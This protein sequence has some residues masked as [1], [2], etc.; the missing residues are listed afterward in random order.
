MEFVAGDSEIADS[1][2]QRWLEEDDEILWE[3]L[4][5]NA[6]EKSRARLFRG[7]HRQLSMTGARSARGCQHQRELP[8]YES[9]WKLQNR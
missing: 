5:K 4:K 7:S 1:T 8:P 2:L 6:A 3:S 9:C